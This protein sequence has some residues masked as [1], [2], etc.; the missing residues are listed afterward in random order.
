M[1]VPIRPTVA[2]S[3]ISMDP[4]VIVSPTILELPRECISDPDVRATAATLQAV[5]L[6]TGGVLSILT[7]GY[8]GVYGRSVERQTDT[9][10]MIPYLKGTSMAELGS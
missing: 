2:T 4:S 9:K 3:A 5:A 7:T 1:E 10:M 6:T 8:W